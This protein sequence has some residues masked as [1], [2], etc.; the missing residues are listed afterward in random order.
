MTARSWGF[1][2]LRPHQYFFTKPFMISALTREENGTIKLTITIPSQEVSKTWEEITNEAIKT[3]E[4]PGFRAGKAPRK[5]LIEKLDQ[6]KIR[7]E[8]LRKLLPEY[9]LGAVTEHKIKPIINP[10]I[11]IEKIEDG[12]DWQFT[13]LTSEVP[14]VTLGDYKES[15]KKLT[16]KSKI[17][18]PGKEEKKPAFEEIVKVMLEN[19]KVTIPQILIEQEVDRLLSQLLDEVKKLGLT[20]D[21][22]LSSSGKTAENLRREY[23]EKAAY[24]IKIEF[25]LQKIAEVEKITVEEKEI[26]EAIAKAKDENEKKNLQANRYLLASILRQQKT[27]DYLKNL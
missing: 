5:L 23:R 10:K 16:A 15:I 14:L 3:V 22:Y 25:V 9:Y 27:L 2:S 26:E 6:N 1:K 21:Q 24:D 8:V 4:I 20:L 17:I 12:K 13:A 18:V 11:H 19:V 7:E